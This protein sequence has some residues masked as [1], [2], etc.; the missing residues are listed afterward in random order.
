MQFHATICSSSVFAACNDT[1]AKLWGIYFQVTLVHFSSNRYTLTCIYQLHTRNT[2]DRIC[3]WSV[4]LLKVLRQVSPDFC[5]VLSFDAF[6]S[7][8]ALWGKDKVAAMAPTSMQKSSTLHRLW[9]AAALAANLWLVAAVT[10]FFP[11]LLIFLVQPRQA[12]KWSAQPTKHFVQIHFTVLPTTAVERGEWW[13][14]PASDVTAS[15][16]A[17]G[18]QRIWLAG[19]RV[20]GQDKNAWYWSGEGWLVSC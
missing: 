19:V 17:V 12:F 5:F 6:F 8:P 1:T 15:L 18:D 2:L 7:Y 20:P 11:L 13:P 4:P 16:V 10:C 9:L 3:T 14:G